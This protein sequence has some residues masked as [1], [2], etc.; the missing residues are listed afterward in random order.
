MGLWSVYFLD[1]STFLMFQASHRLSTE[2]FSEV[3]QI[4]F[5]YHSIL[6]VFR[7]ALNF[8]NLPCSECVPLQILI[9]G[10]F[11]FGFPFIKWF[12][13]FCFVLHKSTTFEYFELWLNFANSKSLCL[14]IFFFFFTFNQTNVVLIPFHVFLK[15]YE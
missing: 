1:A 15:S 13:G 4:K 9:K 11:K 7:F 2:W 14:M 12:Q 3:H 8:F 5:E 10:H 6:M